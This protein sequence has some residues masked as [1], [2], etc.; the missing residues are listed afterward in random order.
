MQRSTKVLILSLLIFLMG[1]SSNP[2]EISLTFQVD[3]SNVQKE[4]KDPGTVG[5]IGSGPLLDREKRKLLHR[6]NNIYQIQLSFPDSLAGTRL[7]YAF[8]VDSLNEENERYPRR[9]LLLPYKSTILPVV[10]FDDLI[11]STGDAILPS[12][13]IPVWRTNTPE[14]KAVLSEPF[15]GITSSGVV[16]KNLFQIESTGFPTHQIKNATE[17][18]FNSLAPEQLDRCRFDISDD[19]WRKWHNIEIYERQG[20]ALYEMSDEQKELAFAILEASL[21]PQG[22]KKSKDIMAMEEYLRDLSLEMS[23]VSEARAQRFGSEK[24]Y[25]TF[26]GTPSETKPWG[27]QLD[28]HHLVINYFVLGDQVVMTPTFMGSEP[29]FIEKGQ[30]KGLRTFEQEEKKGLHFYLA[31]NESQKKKATLLN[32]KKYGF[33]QAEAFKDN[34]VIPYVGLPASELDNAQKDSLLS[35]VEEYIGNMRDQHA[36]VKMDEIKQHV[37]NTWFSWVG[38]SNDTSPFYYR[39]HSPVILIEFDHQGPTLLWD[40][41]GLRP[42]PHKKHVHTVVRTPNG[43]DYGKDLL[44]QHLEQHHH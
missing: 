15:V 25:F 42:G 6:K 17:A 26:M 23:Y 9:Q 12:S 8:I 32:V 22:L 43:N 11:G 34:Q 37:D 29:N 31:L 38:S 4:I 5:I 35:L 16:Q 27:W 3:I 36:T 28:G 41:K 7:A 10:Q 44:R 33:A 39:I 13:P 14:E 1:C 20:I 2:N 40:R 18:F 19:E 24:F 30:N 21:S